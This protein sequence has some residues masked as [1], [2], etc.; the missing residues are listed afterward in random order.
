MLDPATTEIIATAPAGSAADIDL[1]VTAATHA[2][3]QGAWSHSTAGTRAKILWRTAELLEKNAEMLTRLEALNSGML[4][5]LASHMVAYAAETFRYYAGYATKIEGKTVNLSGDQRTR[6]PSLQVAHRRLRLHSS[7]ERADHAHLPKNRARARR[8][9][10]LRR[11]AGRGNSVDGAQNRGRFYRRRG[12]ESPTIVFDDADMDRA[13]PGAAAAIFTNSGQTLLCGLAP[14]CPTPLLRS[15]G[16][17]H[18]GHRE[19]HE[20]RQSVRSGAHSKTCS[21]LRRPATL[22]H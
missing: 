11:Q 17:I 12:F 9:V 2:F 3:R 19:E 14:V 21:I 22:I 10:H 16:V 15:C 18:C 1:A 8:G 20:N 6:T 4:L 13:I 7:M 5:T